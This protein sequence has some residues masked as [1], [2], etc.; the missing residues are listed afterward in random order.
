MTLLSMFTASETDA[1]IQTIKKYHENWY[2]N[3]FREEKISNILAVK[4]ITKSVDDVRPENM[5]IF[6]V[7]TLE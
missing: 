5:R 7:K 4:F 6:A 2:G 1:E 3:L